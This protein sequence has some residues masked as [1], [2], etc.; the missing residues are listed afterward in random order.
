MSGPVAAEHETTAPCASTDPE[1]FHNDAQATAAKKLC[2]ECP[3]AT[4]CRTNA[5]ANR[6]WGTWGGETSAERA[7][8]GHPPAG[9]RGRGHK[10]RLKPCGTPAA[11]R[12]HLR[13]GQKPCPPCKAAEHL[14]YAERAERRRRRPSR[15][16]NIEPERE[17]RYDRAERH[18]GG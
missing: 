12:R 18:P 8:A 2:A 13:K 16:P 10:T 17:A 5:R 14:R 11:Y 15:C 4:E 1:V 3:L 7:A 9:W 6:E